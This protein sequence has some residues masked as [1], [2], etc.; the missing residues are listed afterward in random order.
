MRDPSLYAIHILQHS[1]ASLVYAWHLLAISLRIQEGDG[2]KL[3]GILAQLTD[4][5][6]VR[7][8]LRLKLGSVD[9]GLDG[10]S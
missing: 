5:Q 8:G 10:C 6:C 7:L 1:P 9:F 4:V 2:L 3:R